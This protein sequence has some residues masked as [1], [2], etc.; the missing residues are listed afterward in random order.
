MEKACLVFALSAALDQCNR[1]WDLE[2]FA[3]EVLPHARGGSVMT[4]A[5][6]LLGQGQGQAV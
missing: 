6:L 5:G 2:E 3:N 1:W 4:E